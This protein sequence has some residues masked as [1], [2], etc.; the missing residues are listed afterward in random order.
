MRHMRTQV[1][2]MEVIT[3]LISD[4]AV[5]VVEVVT[6][7]RHQLTVTLDTPTWLPSMY[8]SG[9]GVGVPICPPA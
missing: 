7:L 5:T 9:M 8:S 3:I 4:V 6:G 2:T 1:A